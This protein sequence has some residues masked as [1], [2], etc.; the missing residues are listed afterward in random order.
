MPL[1]DS[2]KRLSRRSPA[3]IVGA[4]WCVMIW[5]VPVYRLLAV[6]YF[7]RI[8]LLVLGLIAVSILFGR[9]ARPRF[10]S[11]WLLAG[12]GIVL[13]SIVSSG[14]TG[15]SIALSNGLP[16][17]VLVAV[18]PFVLRYLIVT[19][20][21][22][23][24]RAVTGFVVVQTLSALAGIAQTTFG[25]SPLG[26]AARAGRANG[27]AEH[28]NVLGLMATLTVLVCIYAIRTSRGGGR[29]LWLM[30]ALVINAAALIATGSLSSL[31]AF[32]AGLVVLIPA[33]R[34]TGRFLVVGICAFLVFAVVG[35]VSG[36]GSFFLRDT[37]EGRVLDVTGATGGEGSFSIRQQ[38]WA[39]AWSYIQANP[40]VGV[41]MDSAREAVYGTTATHNYLL[42]YWYRGGIVL[43]LVGVAITLAAL[44]VVVR[45][46]ATGRNGLSA[47]VLI[48]FFIFAATSAFFDNPNYWI[49]ILLAFA[50]VDGH[51]RDK[52]GDD[53]DVR[54]TDA[55][56]AR[57]V[58]TSGNHSAGARQKKT[59]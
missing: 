57:D 42:H 17:A 15:I 39:A 59:A 29:K 18:A 16:L 23:L 30:V 54:E 31:I 35:V 24:G 12:A 52:P 13:A 26:F 49:P 36:G 1:R 7:S 47:A 32:V 9:V 19:D 56:L 25:A 14:R 6:N 48:T 11:L 4:L 40:L 10:G 45:A 44:V 3:P 22:W 50:A 51:A 2:T 41:G 27:F 37:I 34:I 55:R 5:I 28:P 8:S 33:T 43:V 21:R 38:T 46:I 58:R 20:D 53:P